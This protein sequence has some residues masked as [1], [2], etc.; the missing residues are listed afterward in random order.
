MSGLPHFRDIYFSI[1][2][3]PSATL[4]SK[5][6]YRMGS[7]KLIELQMQLEQFLKKG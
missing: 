2:L 1:D 5:A 4:V 3:V 7:P 6:P